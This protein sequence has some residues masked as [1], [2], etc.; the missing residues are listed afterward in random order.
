MLRTAVQEPQPIPS[1]K[2]FWKLEDMDVVNASVDD[3]SDNGIM[4]DFKGRI[5]KTHGTYEVGLPWKA[6]VRLADTE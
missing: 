2:R 3:P 5:A 6:D 4:R 1:L